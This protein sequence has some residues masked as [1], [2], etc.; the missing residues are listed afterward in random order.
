MAPRWVLAWGPLLLSP[1]C[2]D[3]LAEPL[4][5]GTRGDRKDPAGGIAMSPA[6]LAEAESRENSTSLGFA[7]LSPRQWVTLPSRGQALGAARLGPRSCLGNPD[8]AHQGASPQPGCGTPPQSSPLSVSTPRFL[9][10]THLGSAGAS[11]L[12]RLPL[13][14]HP[15]LS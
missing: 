13:N 7:W 1:G 6:P 2:D 4:P 14:P 10:L 8:K 15:L 11:S 3:A 12:C 5:R 9:P